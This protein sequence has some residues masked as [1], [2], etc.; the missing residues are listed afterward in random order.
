MILEY[1]LNEVISNGLPLSKDAK[2]TIVESYKKKSKMKV[3]TETAIESEYSDLLFDC[4]S[5]KKLIENHVN[6]CQLCG[7]GIIW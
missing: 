3:D 6:Y 4:P 1:V 2:T 5:C 7:I